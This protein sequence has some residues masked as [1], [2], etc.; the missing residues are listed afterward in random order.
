MLGQQGKSRWKQSFYLGW[1]GLAFECLEVLLS[2]CFLA[3]AAAVYK[4]HL[5]AKPIGLQAGA[6]GSGP[7]WLPRTVLQG[8]GP[9]VT[10]FPSCLERP[11]QLTKARNASSSFLLPSSQPAASCP[12]A[13]HHGQ[14]VQAAFLPWL[15]LPLGGE[16]DTPEPRLVASCPA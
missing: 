14:H 6:H 9:R 16:K 1:L 12:V 11:R 13:S 3:H 8:Q 5:K 10:S 4:Q 2:R 7:A 15:W